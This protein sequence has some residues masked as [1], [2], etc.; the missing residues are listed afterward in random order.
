[1]VSPQGS[2]HLRETL[3]AATVNAAHIFKFSGLLGFHRAV[4]GSAVEVAAI[5]GPD[6]PKA[7]GDAFDLYNP[8]QLILRRKHGNAGRL[9]TTAT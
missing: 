9:A 3:E 2:N 6:D 8:R 7:Y 4:A 1:L 5:L